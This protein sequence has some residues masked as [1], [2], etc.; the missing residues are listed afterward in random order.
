ML[1][2]EFPD[3]FGFSV[4]H[5]TRAPRPGEVDGEHYHFSTK[6][7]MQPLIDAG[8]FVESC[9]VHSNLYGTS[10]K[11]VRDVS[12]AG[13]ICILDIDVQGARKVAANE[14]ASLNARFIFIAPPSKE[15][16]HER[17]RGRGTE[18]EAAMAIRLKNADEELQASEDKDFWESVLIN[19]DL[20]RSYPEFKALLLK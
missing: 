11:A 13:K 5:T 18:D 1:M 7:E 9:E 10:I 2:K 3:K 19:D 8:E 14:K 17:L 4:S 20:E 12:E 15:T 16:L 6:E